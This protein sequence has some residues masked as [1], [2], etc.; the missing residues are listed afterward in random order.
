MSKYENLTIYWGQNVKGMIF[1]YTTV[2]LPSWGRRKGSP[3]EAKDNWVLGNRMEDKSS[4]FLHLPLNHRKNKSFF[5]LWG[6][7]VFSLP[8]RSL[9]KYVKEVNEI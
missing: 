7:I 3:E 2:A 4:W 1:V 6:R 5:Q 8:G 9:W